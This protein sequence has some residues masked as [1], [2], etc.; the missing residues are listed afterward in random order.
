MEILKCKGL[1]LGELS[2]KKWE[3]WQL[4]RPLTPFC[5][6]SSWIQ[7]ELMIMWHLLSYADTC[8]H[9][10]TPFPEKIPTPIHPGWQFRRKQIGWVVYAL[11]SNLIS[12]LLKANAFNGIDTHAK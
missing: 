4:F 11:A 9:T 2:G 10:L 5:V 1:R 8:A 7:G 6:T 3:V 12:F